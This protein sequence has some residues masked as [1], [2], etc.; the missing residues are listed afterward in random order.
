MLRS[1]FEFLAG[2]TLENQES[3]FEA[4][5]CKLRNQGN[6]D[7]IIQ[8]L[9]KGKLILLLFPMKLRKILFIAVVLKLSCAPCTIK[10]VLQ[11]G[12]SIT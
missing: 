2:L 12:A 3:C 10:V 1:F 8:R 11:K 9:Q 5:V 4:I 6:C 7:H